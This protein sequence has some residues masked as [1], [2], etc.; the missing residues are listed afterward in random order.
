MRLPYDWK[1]PEA[2]QKQ[3][4]AIN[5]T[6]WM[7]IMSLFI[8]LMFWTLNSAFSD[9]KTVMPPSFLFTFSQYLCPF[10]FQIPCYFVLQG[11]LK[12]Y[13]FESNFSAHLTVSVS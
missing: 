2:M 13:T 5:R 4:R 10:I 11:V 7:D 1:V 12:S 3:K 6:D 8:H 9:M